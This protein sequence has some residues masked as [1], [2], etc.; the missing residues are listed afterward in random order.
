MK[1]DIMAYLGPLLMVAVL[2]AA[3]VYIY[4]RTA[5]YRPTDLVHQGNVQRTVEVS[6]SE[7]PLL[8]EKVKSGELPPVRERLP[9]TPVFL[10]PEERIGQY[11]GVWE[12]AMRPSND[13]A[14]FIRTIGY[15][16]LVRWN[17]AWTGIEPNL[18]RSYS[19][20]ADA[21]EYTFFLREGLKWSDGEPF[22]ADDIVF[23]YEDILLNPELSPIKPAWLVTGGVP[24][25]VE[26]LQ[27]YAV[28]LVFAA[29]NGL[30]LAN[31]AQVHGAEPT[32]YPKH[33][34]AQFLPKYNDRLDE[35]VAAS[36]ADDWRDLF[37]QKL[38]TVGSVDSMDRWQNPELPVLYAWQLANRYGEAETVVARRNPYYWKADTAG[39]QLP[40][41]DEIH[42]F[43]TAD[44]DEMV[45]RALAGRI[46]MQDRHIG[47]S[48]LSI[49][50]YRERLERG[51][52]T[53]GYRLFQTVPANM[54]SMAI[55]LNLNHRDPILRRLFQD[56]DFRVA[57]SLAIDRQGIIDRAFEGVGEP[58]QLAPRP[59][60]PFYDEIMAKQY[61]EHDDD[62][63]NAI[64]DSLGLD[65]R[66]AEGIRL[67]EDG[68]PL[69]FTIEA[70]GF[71]V[72]L[73]MV[74]DQ[75]REVGLD[76]RLEITSDRKA[77]YDRKA[78][79]EHDAVVWPGD[80]GLDVIQ[81]PRYYFPFSAESNYALDWAKWFYAP[82][83]AG[84]E[85]PPAAV[86]RQQ[87]LYRDIIATPDADRQAVIMK[88]ILGIARE[89]F[90]A[91]GVSLTERTYGVVSDDFRNVPGVMPA[92]WVYP[93]PAPTNPSQY[94]IQL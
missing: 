41:I 11:G 8:S 28:K 42:F 5:N 43:V 4:A 55:S 72:A 26:K 74:K 12:A 57:V 90:Y 54:N 70:L 13:H 27:D 86:R 58:Y 82:Q 63:A 30:F 10:Q 53:G 91:I 34:L 52:E 92:G 45:E 48:A 73:E 94:Y 71:D 6:F 14:S 87:E 59:E 3:G 18:A 39:N 50:S 64:L 38:G 83:D 80:G 24:V 51:Q 81:E 25:R 17:K 93:N 46:G 49:K 29:P 21:R 84:A 15:E 44:V 56:K 1:K 85:E 60:S 35:L 65:R 20:S 22:T 88:E 78:A 33:Y 66:D 19:V 40:Y 76:A 61:T 31:L 89:Q 69:R 47:N 7:S 79:G 9:R 77:F 32:S 2:V 16:N 67:M 68:R 62:R 75:L 36:G 23:W 37:R